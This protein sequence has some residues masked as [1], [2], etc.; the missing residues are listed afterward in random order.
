MELSGIASESLE[1]AE[2]IFVA[3]WVVDTLEDAIDT[4]PVDYI[5]SLVDMPADNGFALFGRPIL[6]QTRPSWAVEVHAISWLRTV[7]NGV[8][9]MT[10]GYG[11]EMGGGSNTFVNHPFDRKGFIGMEGKSHY[12][13]GLGISLE[14]QA[15][16]SHGGYYYD[17]ETENVSSEGVW[18]AISGDNVTENNLD[19][20]ILNA[21][22]ETEVRWMV[23]L[24]CSL[25]LFM[26]EVK[27]IETETVH[28]P[29]Q[30]RRQMERDRSLIEPKVKIIKL[31][32]VHYPNGYQERPQRDYSVRWIVRGHWH[33]F[34]TGRK[35]GS[36]ERRLVPRWVSAY[37]KGPEDA[38][39]N[40]PIKLF[41]VTR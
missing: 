40:N 14:E 22:R 13:M 2:T 38:P 34:W 7:D 16:N 5:P 23:R 41:S 19:L 12:D 11:R 37:V 3:D 15:V 28:A 26:G 39:L 8:R 20:R 32:A 31:R 1:R 29:R 17:E 35:D 9:L 10:Y 27:V 36:E 24:V 18:L 33:K 6:I 4:F 21:L 25:W 30:I